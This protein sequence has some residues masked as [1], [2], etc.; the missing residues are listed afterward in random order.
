MCLCVVCVWLVYPVLH[1]F[2]F[3]GLDYGCCRVTPGVGPYSLQWS[4]GASI[5]L[6]VGRPRAKGLYAVLWGSFAGPLLFCPGLVR[7]LSM[8]WLAFWSVLSSR[9]HWVLGLSVPR[10][11]FC[12][13]RS[14]SPSNCWHVRYMV[15]DLHTHYMTHRHALSLTLTRTIYAQATIGTSSV[16]SIT[17]MKDD[18][19]LLLFSVC[20]V[21]LQLYVCFFPLA[22]RSN[23][24][25][26]K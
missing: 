15:A 13:D 8:A 18:P 26:L 11:A 22:F 23:I 5:S 6:V 17:A 21:L 12:L 24:L 1:P 16:S 10:L 19:L 20:N 25:F 14:P 4:T 3:S 9:G 7:W 2:P